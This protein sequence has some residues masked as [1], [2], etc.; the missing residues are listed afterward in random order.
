MPS[1]LVFS[2]T[3]DALGY[4]QT[5]TSGFTENYVKKKK[6]PVF[7]NILGKNNKVGRQW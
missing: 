3:A 6:Q 4:P 7:S 1:D 5:A 2:E